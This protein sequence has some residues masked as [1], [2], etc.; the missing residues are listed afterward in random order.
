M[1]SIISVFNTHF[2]EFLDDILTIFPTNV[3]ILTAKNSILAFKKIN[4]SI[5]IK[6]WKTYISNVY[7]EQIN[8]DDISFFITKDYSKDLIYSANPDKIMEAINE[9]REPIRQMNPGDQQK[10]M[11]YLKNLTKLSLMYNP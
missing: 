4:P 11:K 8:N 6:V 7:L 3:N 9:L 5:I 2:V 1:T 10:T